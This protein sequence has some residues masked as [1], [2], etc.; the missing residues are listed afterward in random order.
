MASEI[1]S[2]TVFVSSTSTASASRPRPLVITN[3]L[4]FNL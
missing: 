2:A 3:R 4:S 1:T